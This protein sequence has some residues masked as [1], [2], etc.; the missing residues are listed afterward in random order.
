MN[1][2]KVIC[3]ILSSLDGR[4]DGDF[5]MLPETMEL[6][7]KYGQIRKDYNPDAI[8]NGATTCS[9]IF[10]M[11]ILIRSLIRIYGMSALITLLR[12]RKNMPYV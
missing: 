2:P 11:V 3:H 4:I 8:L 9:E 10:R 6:S 7:R 5:F 1:R 12:K